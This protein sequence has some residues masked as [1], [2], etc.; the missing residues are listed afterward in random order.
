LTPTDGRSKPNRR[1]VADLDADLTWLS[2]SSEPFQI[3]LS[4]VGHVGY[5]AAEIDTAQ[6]GRRQ[7][8]KCFAIQRL[9][10]QADALDT[11]TDQAEPDPNLPRSRFVI[12]KAPRSPYSPDP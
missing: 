2:D 11:S 1:Q 6:D 12:G 9:H 7:R 5:E 3:V 4:F 8:L 10:V